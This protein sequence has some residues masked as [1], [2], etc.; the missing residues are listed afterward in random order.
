MK[1]V[2]TIV[3]FFV[4][5]ITN[6]FSQEIKAYDNAM[7]EEFST[8]LP[9]TVW[10][11]VGSEIQ[12]DDYFFLDWHWV[13][14]ASFPTNFVY[15]INKPFIV[16]V[17]YRYGFSEE[18]ERIVYEKRIDLSFAHQVLDEFSVEILTDGISN[19]RVT[20][21]LLNEEG[22]IISKD[23]LYN[24]GFFD[25]HQATVKNGKIQTLTHSR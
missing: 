23:N 25:T 10:I 6:S 24:F 11:A 13:F 9:D 21:I 20:A 4:L 3:L 22:K 19:G 7:N 18:T 16:D 15:L 5:T 8:T 2:I 12:S 17:P 14:D 1:K